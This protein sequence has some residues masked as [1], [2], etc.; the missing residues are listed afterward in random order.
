MLVSVRP[1]AQCRCVPANSDVRRTS[2]HRMVHVGGV[3]KED[4][5][6]QLDRA[7]VQ[8]NELARRLFADDRFVTSPTRSVVDV[9]Q[10]TVGSL[11]LPHG[12]TFADV[13]A[14]AALRGLSPCA[15]ELAPHLRLQF[16]TQAEGFGGSPTHNRAPPGSL[17]VASIPL[18]DDDDDPRGFYLR[19]I[20]GVLWLRG[21]RSW[22]G[23]V[24]SVTDELVF[25][26]SAV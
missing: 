22:P 9:T 24:W 11:G 1:A 23:H 13:L 3:S 25:A 20:D 16:T 5:L 18:S 10:I 21:Y 7:G 4:L 14:A 6:D 8:L 12:G 2:M 19:R 26:G 15:L 17:T